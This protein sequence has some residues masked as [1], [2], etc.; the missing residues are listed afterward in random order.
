MS[1]ESWQRTSQGGKALL[2][3]DVRNPVCREAFQQDL[4]RIQVGT[5]GIHVDEHHA[6]CM[7]TIQDLAQKLLRASKTGAEKTLAYLPD[8]DLHGLCQGP[9]QGEENGVSETQA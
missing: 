8:L 2:P 5:Y 1:P 9:P 6:V 4:E 7:R 3:A